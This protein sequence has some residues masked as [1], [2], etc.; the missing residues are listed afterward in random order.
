MEKTNDRFDRLTNLDIVTRYREKEFWFMLSDFVGAF[1]YWATTQSPYKI[2]DIAALKAFKEY[3]LE[4]Y[5]KIN[6]MPEMF[7]YKELS[8]IITEDVFEGIPEIE[9]L[10]NPKVSSGEGYSKRHTTWHPDYDFIDLGALARNIFYMM[11]REYIT[12]S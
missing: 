4:L 11:C 7:T 2:L 8:K 1:A 10:N 3:I 6:E 12:Q 9:L 5:P